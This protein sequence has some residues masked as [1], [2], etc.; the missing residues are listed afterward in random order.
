MYLHEL[1]THSHNS[2]FLSGLLKKQ[3]MQYMYF[4]FVYF[5]VTSQKVIEDTFFE[6]IERCASVFALVEP[7]QAELLHSRHAKQSLVYNMR[8]IIAF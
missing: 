2:A 3:D 4:R 6:P 1:N 5:Q 8:Q 7:D